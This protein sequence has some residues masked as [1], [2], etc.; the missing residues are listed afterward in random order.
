MPDPNDFYGRAG[1]QE[2]QA[3]VVQCNLDEMVI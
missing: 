3:H 2:L 1:Q